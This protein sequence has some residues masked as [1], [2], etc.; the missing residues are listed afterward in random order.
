MPIWDRF[1]STYPEIHLEFHV[2][3][4]SIDIVAQGYDAGL[5]PRDRVAADMIAVPVS[6]PST[7]RAMLAVVLQ[8]D[9]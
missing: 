6:G 5:S 1:L 8:P 4:A 3:D 7:V 9:R 2:G